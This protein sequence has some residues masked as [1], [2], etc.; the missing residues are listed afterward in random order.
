MALTK[1]ID[2]QTMG[3]VVSFPDA[4]ITVTGL[5]GGKSSMAVSVCYYSDKSKKHKLPLG[6]S[7]FSSFKP[8][9][10]E[11]NFIEQAYNHLKSLDEFAGCSDC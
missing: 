7:C 9:L 8:V 3:K 11:V 6:G 2:V 4:Y 10:N 1:H 5:E